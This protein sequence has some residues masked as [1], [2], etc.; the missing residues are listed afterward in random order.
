[1]G[2]RPTS[3]ER[4]SLDSLDSFGSLPSLDSFW[5]FGSFGSVE[6]LSFFSVPGELAGS[7]GPD[8]EADSVKSRLTSSSAL[9]VRSGTVSLLRPDSL[10]RGA[11]NLDFPAV[12]QDSAPD[13]G[14]GVCFCA[15]K[16][17]APRVA[18]FRLL[19]LVGAEVL[20]TF[21]TEYYRSSTSKVTQRARGQGK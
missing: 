1:M 5:P 20:N 12:P 8:M 18:R 9:S 17:M 2:Q 21:R 10:L 15:A 4:E 3:I 6:S 19:P 16:S 14:S 13:I 11:M 7:L